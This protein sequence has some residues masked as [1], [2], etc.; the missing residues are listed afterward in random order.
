[1]K[2]RPD[3]GAI[4]LLVAASI[5]LL[6]GVAALTVDVGFRYMRRGG[7]QAAADAAALGGARGGLSTARATAIATLNGYTTGVGSTVSVNATTPAG[8]PANQLKVVITTS[9]QLFFGAALGF[10]N[11]NV[12]AQA[13][14]VSSPPVPAVLALSTSCTSPGVQL[15]TNGLT[16]TGDVAS[17]G[18]VNFYGA[19]SNAHVTGGVNYACTGAALG[20]GVIDGSVT[21][22]SPATTDPFASTTLASFACGWGSLSSG[23]VVVPSPFVNGTVYCSGG[24]LDI[25]LTGAANTL[26]LVAKGQINIS[27]TGGTV[28][29]AAGGS[30]FVAYS[31]ANLDCPASQA[32][33][34]GT[35]TITLN[36]NFYAPSGCINFSGDRMTINGALIGEDVQ[37]AT[38]LPSTL[39]GPGG[40]GGGSGYL[41]N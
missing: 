31:T 5:I 10:A 38:G 9:E 22:S 27:G 1:M 17:N 25:N 40:G 30:G 26:T 2:R 36:G 33:N 24:K 8:P 29:A 6:F 23:D 37:I 13:T 3:Q 35:S 39:T 15:N 20:G 34:I 28:T 19:T 4:A 16:L 11:R 12:S 41:L 21:P 18:M 7:L 14:A 32:I